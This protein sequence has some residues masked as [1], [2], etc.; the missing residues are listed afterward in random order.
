MSYGAAK[1]KLEYRRRE[2]EIILFV[3]DGKKGRSEKGINPGSVELFLFL[4]P[5]LVHKKRKAKILTFL[6]LW[7]SD[8]AEF[9]SAPVLLMAH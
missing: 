6:F 5:V 8:R 9:E 7:L 1:F 2:M 4:G 3:F